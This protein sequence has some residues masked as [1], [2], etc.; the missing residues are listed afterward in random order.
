MLR[1]PTS[2][3]LDE[4]AGGHLD[5]TQRDELARHIASCPGC[6]KKLEA[7]RALDS[8]LNRGLAAHKDVTS[9]EACLPPIMLADYF[10][11][12]LTPEQHS[13]AEQHLAACETC[14]S[15]LLGIKAALKTRQEE[16]FEKLDDD[17]RKKIRDLIESGLDAPGQSCP[18]CGA[19]NDSEAAHC[20]GCGSRLRPAAVV[21]LCM[22]C[23]RPIPVGSRFCPV[24]GA[25][26][27]A[28]EKTMGFLF[29][30]RRSAAE[31]LRAHAWFLLAMASLAASFFFRRY[32][33]QCI[34]VSLIFGAKWMLDQAQFKIYSEILK[35]L[36]KEEEPEKRIKKRARRGR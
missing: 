33:I 30:R 1:H 9:A 19:R 31:L 13:A 6:A 32:F 34:A 18:A 11:G 8:L 20:S 7:F 14:R 10:D 36:K 28:P 22:A 15:S 26:I 2:K 27:A 5:E 23:G 12:L 4:Y 29:A 16:G 24:C 21:L 17:A 35:S 3:K 25:A